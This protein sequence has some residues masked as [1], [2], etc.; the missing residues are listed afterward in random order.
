[1]VSSD[2]KLT[3]FGYSSSQPS[4]ALWA[5]CDLAGIP[6]EKK[7]I[8]LSKGQQRSPEYKAINPAGC[9]PAILEETP[10]Q[11]NFLLGESHA[12]MRYLARSRG[13]ADHWYPSDLRKRAKVERYLDSH[14]SGLRDCIAGY[15]KRKFFGV[16]GPHTEEFLQSILDKQAV[17]FAELEKI[18]ET[19]EYLAGDEI[20]IADISAA[21][22]LEQSQIMGGVPAAYP[23][24]EAWR[25]KVLD[26]NPEC[27]KILEPWRALAAGY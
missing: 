16:E 5:F 12:C 6:H 1:M 19:Q 9:V 8:D 3:V 10:G 13:V 14:H 7:V 20:S 25:V 22:E 11:P 4:R 23:K 17:V 2:T 24:L 15:I 18:L 27:A 26:G 21:M